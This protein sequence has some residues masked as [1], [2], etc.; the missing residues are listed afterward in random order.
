[1]ARPANA[2][3]AE[4]IA[5]IIA[6]ALEEL[7]QQDEPTAPA[8]RA[9]AKRAGVGLGTIQYYFESK[10]TLL[11][12]CLDGY[13]ER[14]AALAGS[15]TSSLRH[16]FSQ[17]TPTEF[18]DAA[19]AALFAFARKERG[20][21]RF[22]AAATFSRGELA[23]PRQR[24][25]MGGLSELA[26]DALSPH[27]N[28]PLL[29]ARLAVH[30]MSATIVRFALMSDAEVAWATGLSGEAAHAAMSAYVPRAARR[31]LRLPEQS[32]DG[33]EIKR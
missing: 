21:L 13:H 12:A 8:L 15:L 18:V 3:S 22:R 19:V 2:D 6:A 25:F 29:D 1:M 7:A 24:D 10:E 9:V 11:E 31:L 26:A 27:V 4:T 28:V 20:L 30:A 16:G 32:E 17:S 5:R 23:P 33:L 14:L